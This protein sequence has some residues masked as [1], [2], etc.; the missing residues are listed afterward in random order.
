MSQKM[1]IDCPSCGRPLLV[2]E[3]AAGRKARCTECD[4]RFV[5][6]SVEE[7]LEQTVSNMV[8]E[9][10]DQRWHEDETELPDATPSAGRV[11]ARPEY[12]VS[13]T[14]TVL[15]MPAVSD[16]N[17]DSAAPVISVDHLAPA[18][19]DGDSAA[20]VADAEPPDHAPPPDDADDDRLPD[21]GGAH[22]PGPGVAAGDY[23][24]DLR[25]TEPRPY[26]VVNEVS[27]TGVSL[28]FAAEWMNHEVFR[29]SMPIRCVFTGKGPG[30]ALVSRP[31]IAVNRIKGDDDHARARAVE[32]RYEQSLGPKHSPREHVRSIGRMDKMTEPFDQPLLYYACAGHAGDAVTCRARTD[33]FGREHVELLIPFGEVAVEWV[34]RVNGRCGP[35]Y[36]RLKTAVAAL[37]NDGWSSLPEKVQRRLQTWCRFERGERFKLYLRDADLT[38]ADAGLGGVVVTDR[39]LLY[40]KFRRSRSLSLK[41]EAVLHLRPDDRYVRLT[42]ESHGRLA[43][44][45]K[46]LRQDMNKLIQ[47]VADAPRLRVMVGHDGPSDDD[48]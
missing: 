38:V 5:I 9:E 24:T 37:T 15:G 33:D 12:P 31:L 39:R 4:N 44:A 14:G 10:L 26:L 23:P 11:G 6:P 13:N 34:S 3:A 21:D 41:Q 45:G 30:N 7:M 8:L 27:M 43:R 48:G 36:A 1:T 25:P 28:S 46:I 20:A 19:D 16:Q 18:S 42:L 22:E 32:M 2:P 40:H 35:E 29:T 17:H 47:S